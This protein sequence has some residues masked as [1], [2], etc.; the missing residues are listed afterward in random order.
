M[1]DLERY[2]RAL[3]IWQEAL[4]RFL[5]EYRYDMVANATKRIVTLSGLIAQC[6]NKQ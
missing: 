2:Q 6:S 3:L 4:N 1:T 5:S